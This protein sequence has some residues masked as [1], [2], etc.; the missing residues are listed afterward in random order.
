M[1]IVL[2]AAGCLLGCGRAEPDRATVADVVKGLS[3]DESK[4]V[5]VDEP[6]GK[7][8]AL[9]CTATLRDTK[10]KVR[11]R[12]EVVYTPALFSDTRK[13]D[14]KAVRAAAVRNVIITPLGADR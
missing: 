12:I 14:A 11:V 9:E 8:E 6:P 5:Y 7:L 10:V 4:L 13:W 2:I 3:L 1:F